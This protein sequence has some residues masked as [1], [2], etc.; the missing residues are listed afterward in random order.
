MDS[1]QAAGL[2]SRAHRLPNRR[3]SPDYAVN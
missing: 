3:S 2:N 1:I